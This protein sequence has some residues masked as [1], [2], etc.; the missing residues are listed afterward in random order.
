VK[1]S[2][3]TCQTTSGWR[4]E[5]GLFAGVRAP[6]DELR[7]AGPH[8]VTEGA[9]DHSESRTRLAL[10]VAG[11]HQQQTL[12]LIGARNRGVDHRLLAL[13]AGA[14]ALVDLVVAHA[15]SRSR[16]YRPKRTGKQD[17]C[18]LFPS[19]HTRASSRSMIARHIE[20]GMTEK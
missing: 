11:E 1:P 20:Q 9:D 16:E 18:T 4:T 6:L 19:P 5:E 17:E 7:D 8:A 15:V 14:V 2:P 12:V 13:H 3:S 10:A